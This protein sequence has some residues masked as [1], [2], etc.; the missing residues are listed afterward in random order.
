ME[1][2]SALV[3]A[4]GAVH[5]D[6]EAAIHL[7]FALVIEPGHA[8]HKDPFGLGNAFQDLGFVILR[9]AP[10]HGLQGLEHFHHGLVEFW[11]GWVLGFY[12]VENLSGV[13]RLTMHLGRFHDSHRLSSEF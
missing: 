6:A 10:Q 12:E 9:V 11:F 3:G 1:A 13:V 4:D 2:Q 8:E 5:L 7:H